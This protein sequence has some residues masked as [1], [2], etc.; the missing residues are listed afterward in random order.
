MLPEVQAPW[1]LVGCGRMGTALLKGWARSNVVV[2]DPSA[3]GALPDLDAAGDIAP[4]LIVLAVKPQVLP[5]I[6][7][8]YA[9]FAKEATF[10]SIAAGK[11]L[12][13]L[14]DWLGH[15]AALVRAMPNTPAAIG[16][17][18]SVATANR[19]V[20]DRGRALAH[21]ALMAGG[22]VEW[23]EDEGLLDAVTALSGS[24][25]AYVF[26]LVEALAQ[27]GQHLGLPAELAMKLARQT[28]IGS[29]HLLEQSP[30]TAAALREAVTSP[31]GTTAAALEVL[32]GDNG[33]KELMLAA[34]VAAARRSR[35]LA[36]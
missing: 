36:G 13:A 30:E 27:A 4:E 9:R 29:G 18:I 8:L 19:H 15:Q 21:Q 26:H 17:G 28:V 2:I 24:G 5:Q 6:A 10:L 35:E 14:A 11:P 7:P 25:P 31:G 16:K 12:A 23:V 22:Q 3:P 33:L 1:L 32:M 20:T 34:L